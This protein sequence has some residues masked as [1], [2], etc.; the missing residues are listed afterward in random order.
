MDPKARS[1]DGGSR[2]TALFVG[3]LVGAFVAGFLI[4]RVLPVW[5][6]LPLVIVAV[7]AARIYRV[8]AGRA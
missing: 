1:G 8:R 7:V 3:S 6:G 2:R 4:M 5:L